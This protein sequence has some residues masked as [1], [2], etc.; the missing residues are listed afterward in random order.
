MAAIVYPKKVTSGPSV[1]AKSA[2]AS[3]LPTDFKLTLWLSK[4]C[5]K[6]RD[7]LVSVDIEINNR[8]H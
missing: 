7:D 3:I 4:R 2:G 8:N 1:I 5:F 6:R